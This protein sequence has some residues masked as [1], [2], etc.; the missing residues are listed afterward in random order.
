VS[1]PTSSQMSFAVLPGRSAIL[2]KARA[3]VGP[4]SFATS[5]VEGQ[6]SMTLEGDNLS[7]ASPLSGRLI[8]PLSA[9]TSRNSLYDAEL[10]RRIDTRRFPLATIELTGADRIEGTNRYALTAQ[11]QFHDVVRTISGLVT[12][13]VKDE[14]VAIWGEQTFDVRDFNL[15]VPTTLALKIYP[16]VSVEMHIEALAHGG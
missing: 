14:N 16:D 13:E 15:G 9:L 8:V 10:R 12:L 5:D 11:M 6:I 3:N 4:I 2:V 1:V 7:V